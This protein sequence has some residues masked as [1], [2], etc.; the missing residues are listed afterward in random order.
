MRQP[1]IQ[2]VRR[3]DRTLHQELLRWLSREVGTL[4]AG[5]EYHLN[6]EEQPLWRLLDPV[7]SSLPDQG[8]DKSPLVDKKRKARDSGHDGHSSPEPTQRRQPAPPPRPK[9]INKCLVCKKKHY[10]YCEF[11]EDFRKQMRARRKAREADARANR[12]AAKKDGKKKDEK[13]KDNSK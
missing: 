12:A 1:T 7:V 13:P 5:L 4:N 2:E 11:P 6:R 10:P 3:F 8:I 9:K